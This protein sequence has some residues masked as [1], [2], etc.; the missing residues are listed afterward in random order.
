M[1]RKASRPPHIVN[2]IWLQRAAV[3]RICLPKYEGTIVQLEVHGISVNTQHI[4]QQVEF[5][6]RAFRAAVLPQVLIRLL[7]KQCSRRHVVGEVKDETNG[8]G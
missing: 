8:Y 2:G 4:V 5:Q 3:R 1:T 6:N 7:F